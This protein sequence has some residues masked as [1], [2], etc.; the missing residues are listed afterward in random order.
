M[1]GDT[2]CRLCY[3]PHSPHPAASFAMGLF[4][5]LSL[6]NI[7]SEGILLTSPLLGSNSARASES[8]DRDNE[9][10]STA[11]GAKQRKAA[12]LLTRSKAIILLCLSCLILL[13]LVSLPAIDASSSSYTD[14]LKALHADITGK[15]ATKW[16]EATTASSSSFSTTQGLDRSW[17]YYAQNGIFVN[18]RNNQ[19]IPHNR[20][21][22]FIPVDK[23]DEFAEKGL[24]GLEGEVKLGD[25]FDE[26]GKYV[27]GKLRKVHLVSQ[28]TNLMIMGLALL[29]SRQPCTSKRS[30]RLVIP[31]KQDCPSHSKLVILRK[32][33]TI[34][35]P[36]YYLPAGRL[37]RPILTRLYLPVYPLRLLPFISRIAPRAA[38]S[39]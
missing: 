8:S 17:D 6:S 14:N 29:S 39:Q 18:A 15:I 33:V 25:G 20:K 23:I 10:V 34:C 12:S 3:S 24:T 31:A 7:R 37:D 36:I 27:Q 22:R 26:I 32:I 2:R 5:R 11:G 38:R 21:A 1:A 30:Q 35:M 28:A 16:R 9:V 13:L 19:T 4:D